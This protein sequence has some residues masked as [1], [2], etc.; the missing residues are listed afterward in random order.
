M[1]RDQEMLDGKDWRKE[2][3]GRSGVILFQLN[4]LKRK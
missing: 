4:Q 1:G 2:R 3:K